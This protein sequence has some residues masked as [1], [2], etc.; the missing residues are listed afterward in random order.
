MKKKATIWYAVQ[1]KGWGIYVEE[2]YK[3]DKADTSLFIK[4]IYGISKSE[5]ETEEVAK[6]QIEDWKRLHHFDDSQV[7]IIT[8]GKSKQLK[9][10]KQMAALA[11]VMETM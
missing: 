11:E 7:T 3:W 9:L 10:C 1:G 4:Q 8:T 2:S 5:E 6:Q